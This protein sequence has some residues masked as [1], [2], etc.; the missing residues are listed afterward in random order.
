MLAF[1]VY[2]GKRSMYLAVTVDKEAGGGA[3]NLGGLSTNF[4]G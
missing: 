2:F 4:I 3:I 1:Q